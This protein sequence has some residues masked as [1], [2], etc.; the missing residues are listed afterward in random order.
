[1]ICL[2]AFGAFIIRLQ[3]ASCFSTSVANFGTKFAQVR[4]HVFQLPCS[5]GTDTDDIALRHEGRRCTAHQI[6][7][8]SKKSYPHG[9]IS[10]T[11]DELSE[12]M[13]GWGRAR[14]AWDFY[15]IGVDPALF[16]GTTEPNGKRRES[17][18]EAVDPTSTGKSLIDRLLSGMEGYEID[19]SNA[20]LRD[21]IRNFLP[22]SRKTQDLGREALERLASTYS[23]S[24]ASETSTSVGRVDGGIASL[25][26]IDRSSDGTT[27]LL[28]RLYDGMEVETVIIPWY[29][30]GWSTLCVSSQVGCRQ[31]CRFCA[32]GKMGLPRN[33]SSDE[34]LAQFFFARKICRLSNGKFPEVSN[35]VF[36]GMGEPTDNAAAVNSALR[37]LTDVDHYHMAQPKVTVSTVGP[38]P[39]AFLK[40]SRSPCVLAWSVHAANDALRKELVPTTRHTMEELRQGLVKAL[41]QRPAKL[42]AT[43]LEVALIAGVNDGMTAADELAALALCRASR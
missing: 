40:F 33:L 18:G 22:T 13:G 24:T 42:R 21:E 28:L 8:P 12:V 39:D 27:K 35:V 23:Y 38:D 25:S 10:M 2:Y 20:S 41:L 7:L 9:A 1:M 32:T 16:F 3:T 37:I 34:I 17:T 6:S 36:M 19:D 5:A 30:K 29:D 15:R 14:L 31:A 26:Q 4:Q 43:M 11:V